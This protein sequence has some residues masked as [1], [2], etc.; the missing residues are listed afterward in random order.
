MTSALLRLIK[1]KRT[2][3]SR[4]LLK[5]SLKSIRRGL[6][7]FVR[8]KVSSLK[9]SASVSKYPQAKKTNGKKSIVS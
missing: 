5:K 2:E 9:Q 1:S 7:R 3:D 6:N 8:K 4:V